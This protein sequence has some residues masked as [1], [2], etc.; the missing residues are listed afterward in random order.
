MKIWAACFRPPKRAR[1]EG[2]SG[3]GAAVANVDCPKSDGTCDGSV[4]ESSARHPNLRPQD[5]ASDK[6]SVGSAQSRYVAV[7]S[8][9]AGGTA[10]GDSPPGTQTQAAAGCVTPV[11]SRGAE[12]TPYRVSAEQSITLALG[13]PA[14]HRLT[15]PGAAGQ[16]MTLAHLAGESQHSDAATS[17]VGPIWGSLPLEP[18]PEDTIGPLVP[19][20]RL[21]HPAQQP[22]RAMSSSADLLESVA[23]VAP[24]AAGLRPPPQHRDASAGPGGAAAA[25]AAPAAPPAAPVTS[26]DGPAWSYESG[27]SPGT[28]GLLQPAMLQPC[29]ISRRPTG[30]R[31][32]SALVPAS[33]PVGGGA[34]RPA[35][36][37]EVG[38]R[39]LLVART[40]SLSP[41]AHPQKCRR[42]VCSR[43]ACAPRPLPT[44][45]AAAGL[46]AA[47]AVRAIHHHKQTDLALRA[48]TP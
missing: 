40:A 43:P 42:P 15:N 28:S 2:T 26:M 38:A 3:P 47:A 24:P 20:P 27:L 36:T 21:Q 11:A 34:T 17:S 12:P 8:W 1:P 13:Q 9:S 31:S 30:G 29:A 14:A 23:V 7:S 45:F 16:Y 48:L 19:S 39:P 33:T 41:C 32:A 4:A 37:G 25:A 44:S 22:T 5:E 10:A 6:A 35:A 18:T 46:P